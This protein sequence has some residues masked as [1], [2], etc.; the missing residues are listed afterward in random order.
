MPYGSGSK[1]KDMIVKICDPPTEHVYTT[2]ISGAYCL[3]SIIKQL[4][5]MYTIFFGII[6][7]QIGGLE[8]IILIYTFALIMF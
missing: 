4:L 6:N 5:I 8:I 2:F 7:R 3:D 1:P